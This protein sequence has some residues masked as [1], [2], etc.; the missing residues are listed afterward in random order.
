MKGMRQVKL[1]GRS[2]RSPGEAPEVDILRSRRHQGLRAAGR[3]ITAHELHGIE[4]DGVG[5]GRPPG[6]RLF[7][8]SS[9]GVVTGVA[10]S[11]PI[12]VLLV[13]VRVDGAV[14]VSVLDAIPIVVQLAQGTLDIVYVGLFRPDWVAVPCWPLA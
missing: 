10:P 1:L 14:V 2:S 11:I 6:I 13:R 12:S 4:E 5:R 9:I 8:V 7:G 3:H